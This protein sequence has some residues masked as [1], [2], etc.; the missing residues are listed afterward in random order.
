[1]DAKKQQ[2]IEFYLKGLIQGKYTASEVARSIGYT[3]RQVVNLKRNYKLKGS[4]SLIHGNT[5]RQSARKVSKDLEL[6]IIS[7]YASKYKDV[8][9]KYYR[10]CL[11]EFENIKISY[12]TLR[13]IMKRAKIHS[14]ESRKVKK[15]KKVHR[16]RLRRDYFGDMLQIDGTP[17]QWFYK[18]GDTHYYNLQGAI[19]DATGK[20]TSLYMTE[21]ECLYGYME[22]L[23]QTCNTYGIPREIYSDRAAI[24]CVTPKDKKN[25]TIWE[26]L[27]GIH[28]KRTQ[29][30]RILSD[31]NINQI[32]AWTPQAKGRV[33]RMWETIQGQLPQWLYLKKVKTMEEANK[34]LPQYIKT[35]NEKY[36]VEPAEPWSRFRPLNEFYDL[37]KILCAQFA[38]KTDFN[39]MFDF[40]KE[41]FTI[42]APQVRHKNFT[43]CVSEKGIFALMDDELYYPVI[44]AASYMQETISDT[45]PKVVKNICYKYLFEQAKEVSI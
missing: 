42:M 30:Q 4:A 12:S 6:K 5:N 41:Q 35:F 16:P 10:D 3:Q 2:L 24:F 19:D 39:G 23:R 15:T 37:D 8:N 44:P 32:L 29:W 1:M 38:K 11:E 40:H 27:Q 25:L 26:E 14:P 17:F 31:L 22:V 36:S 21:N 13:A 43:L 7:I 18:S 34:I 28:E 9:F 33:E 45:M 20:I